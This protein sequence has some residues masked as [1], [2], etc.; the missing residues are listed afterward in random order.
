MALLLYEKVFLI[1][2]IFRLKN[3]R[4]ELGFK[5]VVGMNAL[6]SNDDAVRNHNVKMKYE[7]FEDD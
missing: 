1:K 2:I 4:T 7:N 6:P 5:N 3:L